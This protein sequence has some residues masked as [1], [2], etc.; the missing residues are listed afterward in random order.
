V[1]GFTDDVRTLV[2]M[3]RLVTGPDY[4]KTEHLHRVLID[5]LARVFADVD[6]II[7][8]TCP[9]TAWSIGEWTVR[10]GAQDESVLAASWRLTYPWNLAGLPAISAL[11]VRYQRSA[12]RPANRGS[13]LRRND[14]HSC[15]RCLRARA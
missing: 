10:V 7:G 13:P 11:R 5:D 14:R 3:G 9:L 2:E 12:H 1:T 4:L 6:V 15:R 8:P